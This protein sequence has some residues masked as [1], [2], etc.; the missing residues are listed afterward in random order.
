MDTMLIQLTHQKATGLLR[1]LQELHLIKLLKKKM[2]PEPKN[3][4]KNIKA[5]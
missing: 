5:L 3:F 1:E 4:L 2:L